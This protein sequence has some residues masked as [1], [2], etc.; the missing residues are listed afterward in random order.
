MIIAQTY[1]ELLNKSIALLIPDFDYGGEEKRVVLFA[2]QYTR[3]FKQVYLLAPHG[4]SII[5]LDS[6]VNYIKTNVRNYW[7]IKNAVKLIKREKIDYVQGH[8]RTT[9]PYL[10]AIEKLT[11]AYCVFNFDN[12]YIN[13]NF[14]LKFI[15]PKHIIYLSDIVRDF[16]ASYYKGHITTTINMGG[17]FFQAL[18]SLERAT[19]RT[20]RGWGNK[21]VLL[22]LGRLS[23]QKNQ[24][25]L[26]EALRDLSNVDFLCLL[27]G[28]GPEQ[29]ILEQLV[30]KYDLQ[31]KVKFLGH[32]IAP[33]ELLC[34]ADVLIQTSTF[35]GF[36]NVLIEAVSVGLPIIATN[37]GS[38]A[39][40][41][42][43]YGLLVPSNSAQALTNALVKMS[44]DI[45][46]YKQQ[47]ES[48]RESKFFQQF[49]KDIMVQNYLSYYNS[50]S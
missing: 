30:E 34:L 16:Y 42:S 3:Y 27:A 24:R 29:A 9:L 1:S 36:P 14:L 28:S 38:T 44:Q 10:L 48:L 19:I 32:I 13:Y 41:V 11:N 35:E 31:H 37:V 17:D 25:L 18:T 49:H 26:L 46:L 2:N 21:L 20:S 23:R 33:Q 5:L 40:L 15:S 7:S 4:D 6:K 12:I 22:N 47:S 8:K 45:D 39:T 50:L 43:D